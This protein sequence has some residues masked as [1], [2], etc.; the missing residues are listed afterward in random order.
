MGKNYFDGVTRGRFVT[1][2]IVFRIVGEG[3]EITVVEKDYGDMDVSLNRNKVGKRTRVDGVSYAIS[4]V[5][6]EESALVMILVQ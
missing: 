2:R 1:R 3:D 4:D 6:E 5:F